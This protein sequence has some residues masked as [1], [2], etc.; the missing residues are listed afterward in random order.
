MLSGTAREVVV[1]EDVVDPAA[2]VGLGHGQ[3]RASTA[4]LLRVE[5]VLPQDPHRQVAGA[6][7]QVAGQDRR[8]REV[9]ITRAMASAWRTRCARAASALAEVD[10]VERHG[11]VADA[12]RR[13]EQ[14]AR[15][16]VRTSR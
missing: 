4:V 1:V 8:V 3:A 12:Q 14:P 13:L 5:E 10:R 16:R 6:G 7:V 15:L 2:R 9:R 11:P